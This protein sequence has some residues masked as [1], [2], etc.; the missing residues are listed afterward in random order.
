V[1]CTTVTRKH[2]LFSHSLESWYGWVG[3]CCI[4]RERTGDVTAVKAMDLFEALYVQRWLQ[5]KA[6]SK[7]NATV[8]NGEGPWTANG[9]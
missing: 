7:V 1:N 9:L 2:H 3:G 6:P 4:T 5:G 8:I